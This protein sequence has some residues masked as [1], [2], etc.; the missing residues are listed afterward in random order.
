MKKIFALTALF[1]AGLAFSANAGQISNGQM[2]KCDN[3]KS[4]TLEAAKVAH[5]TS[6]K[7]GFTGNECDCPNPDCDAAGKHPV[8]SNWQHTP[9]WSQEQLETIEEMGHFGIVVLSSILISL[10]LSWLLLLSSQSG[11]AVIPV[12]CA[13]GLGWG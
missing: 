8:A 5:A 13:A 7:Y 11:R 6:D 9:D 3:A 2:A 1:V 4:I 10:S 12:V